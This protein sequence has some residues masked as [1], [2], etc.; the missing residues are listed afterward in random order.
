LP[1]GNVRVVLVGHFPVDPRTF[2]GGVQTSTANLL[3]ALANLGDLELHLV[4]LT[5]SLATRRDEVRDGVLFHYVP[6]PSRLNTLTLHKGARR[7][8]QRE[9]DRIRPHVV[10]ALDALDSGYA[11]LRGLNAYPVVVSVHGIVREELKYV[12]A[13]SDRI[14]TFLTSYLV[15][16][17]CIK[18][19][20][21]LICPTPYPRV[22]FDGLITGHVSEVANPVSDELFDSR[23]SVGNDLLYS[24]AI[25]PRKRLID[26]IEALAA[27]KRLFPNVRLRIAGGTPDS[28]YLSRVTRAVARHRLDENVAL[29]GQLPMAELLDEYRECRALVLPSAQET[30][31]MVI[32]ELMAMGKPIVATRVGGVPYLVDDG[33]TGFVVEAGD[34]GAL[35]DRMTR[36][37]SDAT[38]CAEMGSRGRDKADREFRASVAAR[39]V[40]DVYLRACAEARKTASFRF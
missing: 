6:S 40:C 34:V 18:R 25:I 29:L 16:R 37:L 14:R 15:E 35:A 3:G 33:T 5:P 28:G 11:C 38:L 12:P 10:H 26:L 22:Y 7:I 39:K 31:P 13:A 17:Y 19:A 23:P 30:S 2:A 9:V 20:R 27:V 32:A 8:L 36:L 24:G 21:Y 1:L 4:A